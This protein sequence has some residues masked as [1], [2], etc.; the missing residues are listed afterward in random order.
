MAV[1]QVF[2]MVRKIYA[3]SVSDYGELKNWIGLMYKFEE[4]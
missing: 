3:K 1:N 2:I 4:M